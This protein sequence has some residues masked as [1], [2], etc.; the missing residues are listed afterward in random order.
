MGYTTSFDGAFI[1][2]PALNPDQVAYLRKFSENRRMGLKVDELHSIPDP[3]REAVGL[4]VGV[5]GGYFVGAAVQ[6]HD[7]F[8]IDYNTPPNGQPGLWCQ[9]IPSEDGERIEWDEG[10]KFYSYIEWIVYINNHFL[11][12]WGIVL[13][14]E[15][16]WEG[17]ESS[18]CGSIKAENG[19]IM[20]QEYKRVHGDWQS[21]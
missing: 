12:P 9:W 7:P 17:E 1:C 2:T 4:P 18:D 6:Y 13:G 20:F 10:E 11:K 21:A 8:I 15:V 16:D 14:G 3:L 19:E 5:E